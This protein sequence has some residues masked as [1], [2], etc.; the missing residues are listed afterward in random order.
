MK[1]GEIW[2]INNSVTHSVDNISDED[3]VHFIIDYKLSVV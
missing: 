1:E 2:E 3:R